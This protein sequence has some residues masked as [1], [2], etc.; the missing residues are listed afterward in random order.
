MGSRS[1]LECYTNK[2]FGKVFGALQWLETKLQPMF[3]VTPDDPFPIKRKLGGGGLTIKQKKLIERL[4]REGTPVKKI[5]T[6]A[7]CSVAS[8]YRHRGRKDEA[9]R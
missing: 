1:L 2:P 4:D 8:V 7:K 5:A 6:K 9:K 3:D